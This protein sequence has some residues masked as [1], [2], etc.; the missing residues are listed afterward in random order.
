M[1]ERT[2]FISLFVS[3]SLR[4]MAVSLLSFF[5][6]VYI[7][8][9]TASFIFVFGFFLVLYICQIIG[10][11]LA[12]NLSQRFGLKLQ[13]F[14]GEILTGLTI[15]AFVASKNGLVFLLLASIFWGLSIG[16]F[17]FGRFGLLVKIGEK[18][19]YGKALGLSS[20]IETAFLLVVPF[21]GGLLI[22]QF[23]YPALFLFSFGFVLA[24][25]L[26]LIPLQDQKT[27]RDTTLGEIG[28]LFLT[29]K[30]MVVIYASSGAL[31]A[32]S[33][34]LVLYIFLNIKKEFVFGAF[35]SL[36]MIIVAF[37][38]YLVCKFVDHQKKD[39]FVAG[40]AVLSSLVW[41]GRFFTSSIQGLFIFDVIGRITGGMVG[42]P[43]EV[44]SYEKAL[45][46]HST[47]RAILFREIAIA[48][49]G[50]IAVC[51]LIIFVALN[52]PLK[53]VFLLAAPVALARVLVI[54]R[55][56]TSHV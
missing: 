53:A 10:T 12:E 29:H 25:L 43:L 6:A 15:G 41:L 1:R 52:L 30:R 13:I 22:S 16:F 19:E 45:D 17:W 55:E 33:I 34:A 47:G 44:L 37:S 21:L 49:G 2:K 5:S 56:K 20:N 24:S 40:G 3:Q 42:Y 28:R 4:S 54:G 11:S 8:K 9:Q 38:D 27:H 48:G 31:D 18:G 46:G 23:G 14:L 36:S 32:F 26:N 51:F 50:I 7:Y 39:R 35:F